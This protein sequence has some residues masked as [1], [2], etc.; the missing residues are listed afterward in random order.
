MLLIKLIEIESCPEATKDEPL[1]VNVRRSTTLG[2]NKI[3]YRR[4]NASMWAGD[5]ESRLVPSD[6]KG[7]RLIR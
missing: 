4:K 6:G 3:H 2:D 7:R 1:T 5:E